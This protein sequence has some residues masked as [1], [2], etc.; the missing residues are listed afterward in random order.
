MKSNK[1]PSHR[2]TS[3]PVRGTQRA[4][5]SAVRSRGRNALTLACLAAG[6]T[7]SALKQAPLPPPGVAAA[8]VQAAPA[9]PELQP[10]ATPVVAAPAPPVLPQEQVATAVPLVR[11]APVQPTASSGD[12]YAQLRAQLRWVPVQVGGRELSTPD[13]GSRLLLVRSAAERAGLAEVGLDFRDVYG[14]INAETTWVARTG[15]GRNGVASHGLAQFEPATAR[16]IGVRDANDPVEAVH[17]AAVL[18]KEAALWSAR[19][20]AGR[21]LSGPEYAARLREGV[22]IYYNLSSRARQRW[23]GIATAHLPVETQRHIRNVRIGARQAERLHEGG[24]LDDG[25][26][27]AA[28]STTVRRETTQRSR[29]EATPMPRPQTVARRIAAAR[30]QAPKPLGTIAWSGGDGDASRRAGTHVVWSNG[31]VTRRDDGRVQWSS[32]SP[33]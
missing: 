28:A 11:S 23:D 3:R 15:M 14:V 30:P 27:L 10:V 29:P 5:R 6:V 31:A 1:Q 24:T 8:A 33:G 12:Y 20:I 22:S 17:G 7:G 32:G 4:V 16:A 13:A 9:R 18:L 26:L 19:R 2:S 21:G 25:V